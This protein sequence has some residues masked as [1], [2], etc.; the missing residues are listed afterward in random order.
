MKPGHPNRHH[1]PHVDALLAEKSL[2]GGLRSRIHKSAYFG[3]GKDRASNDWHLQ[4]DLFVVLGTP[5]VPPAAILSLA[6]YVRD[7]DFSQ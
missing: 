4:C 1:R 3:E 7:R 2:L 5:R 6:R